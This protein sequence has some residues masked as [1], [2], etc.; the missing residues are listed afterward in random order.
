M[1]NVTISSGS[2]PTQLPPT[3]D[4]SSTSNPSSPT[5]AHPTDNQIDSQSSGK[6]PGGDGMNNIQA[7]ILQAQLLAQTVGSGTH[8]DFSPN[9]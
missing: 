9:G 4:P 5:N 2:T 1:D 6:R 3:T 7:Q 8:C